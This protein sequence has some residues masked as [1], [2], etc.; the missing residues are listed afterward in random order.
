MNFYVFKTEAGTRR[1]PLHEHRHYELMLYMK[2]RGDLRTTQGNIPFEPG[3]IVIVPPGMRH[4]SCSKDEFCNISIEGE[5]DQYFHFDSIVVAKDNER[6]E[7]SRLV[8]L[9]YENRES[10]GAYLDSLCCAFVNFVLQQLKDESETTRAVKKIA[11]KIA[12]HALDTELDVSQIL[13]N[14]D[15]S[16]D[17]IRACFRKEIGKTPI[18]FLTEIRMKHACYLINIYR[19]SLSLTEISEKCGYRDYIYFS[20]KFKEYTGS[21]PRSY[22]NS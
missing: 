3:V 21:S 4:G 22:R 15:Y 12:A 9:I 11:E 18:E 10:V 14:S 2:G 17:Y 13:R 8:H 16:E 20:K 7:G 5:W 1:Y 19:N 6:S